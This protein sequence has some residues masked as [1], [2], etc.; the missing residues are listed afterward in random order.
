MLKEA[1]QESTCV[2][3]SSVV[4]RRNKARYVVGDSASILWTLEVRVRLVGVPSCLMTTVLLASRI[5]SNF[6]FDARQFLVQCQ[7]R[8]VAGS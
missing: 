6:A 3:V 8:I 1:I 7:L 2:G 4:R 5:F